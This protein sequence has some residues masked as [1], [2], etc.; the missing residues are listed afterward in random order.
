MPI[1]WYDR[2]YTQFL[3]QFEEEGDA[4]PKHCELSRTIHSKFTIAQ[5]LSYECTTHV[6][7]GSLM[8]AVR[9]PKKHGY[10]QAMRLLGQLLQMSAM[11][12]GRRPAAFPIDE[13][14]EGLLPQ[15]GG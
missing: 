6:Q 2:S 5:S 15:T 11:P 8:T 1:G 12:P 14:L 13:P 3:S 4:S 9:V 7:V 10:P